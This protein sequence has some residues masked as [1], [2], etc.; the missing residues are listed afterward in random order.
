MRIPP[1]F[2]ECVAFLTERG[3]APSGTAFFV[4]I[5]EDGKL[6]TYLVTALHNIE[7]AHG[8][9]VNV[10]LNTHAAIQAP[11]GY[12]DLETQKDDWFKHD[13]ADVA[14]ILFA[15]DRTR[16]SFEQVPVDTFIDADYRFDVARLQGRANSRLEPIL[17]ANF[18]N[19]IEVQVGDETFAPGLFVQ[20]AGNNRNLPIVRFGNVARMPGEEMIFLDTIQ[21]GRVAIRAYLV[22]TH[23]WGGFS[24]SP[25]FWHFEYNIAA[26]LT[27]MRAVNTAPSPLDVMTRAPHPEKIEVVTNRG[28]ATALLGLVSG[29]Y[30]IPLKSKDQSVETAINAGIAVV[31][32]AQN[33][34]E[35]LMRPDLVNERKARALQEQNSMPAA[36][37][38]SALRSDT[39]QLRKTQTVIP[40]PTRAAFLK[41]LKKATRRKKP[42]E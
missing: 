33:V 36:T 16:Y 19:G 10:R 40:V 21:R 8:R 41:D 12:E 27:A 14:A 34:R 37:A 28:Y 39:Q 23:S 7:E 18:A 17:R 24:G 22:E 15:V 4:K 5:E 31:T 42:S 20:S 35:L 30:D 29:H 26:A 25:M 6:W 13:R 11:L 38:D 9:H 1:H 2:S 3:K 32:P